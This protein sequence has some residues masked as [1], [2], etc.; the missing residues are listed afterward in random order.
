[1]TVGAAG[2]SVTRTR[3]SAAAM[4]TALGLMVLLVVGIGDWRIVRTEPAKAVVFSPPGGAYERD[5][6]LSLSAPTLHGE[7]VTTLDGSIPTVERGTR[8]VGP[9]RLSADGRAVTTIRARVVGRDGS[10]GPVRTESYFLGLDAQL[11]MM[12]LVIDPDDMWGA[13]R[14]IYANAEQ[15]GVEWERPVDIAYVDVDRNRGFHVPAGVRL[16]GEWSRQFDKK[17]LRLYF[18]DE[19]G[20]TQLAY[21]LFHTG[22]AATFDRLVLHNGGNDSTQPGAN[23]TLLRNALVTELA[24]AIGADTTRTRPVLL[25]VNGDPW[26]IYQLRERI[27]ERFLADRYGILQADILDSPANVWVGVTVEGDHEHWDELLAYVK[28][29]DLHEPESYT[30]VAAQVDLANLI[31]YTL[32]QLYSGNVDWPEHNVNQ[33]RARSPGGRWRWI[34]WDN[35][36]SFGLNLHA[37]LGFEGDIVTLD[38]VQKLFEDDHRRV[39]DGEDTLLTRKLLANEHFRGRFLA[40]AD[41]LLETAFSAEAVLPRIDRLAAEL[42][43]DIDHEIARWGSSVDWESSVEGMRDYARR[44][45]DALREHLLSAL[46]P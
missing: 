40:R 9:I 34:V 20:P 27:D 32:L 11:P 29:H 10:L 28:A 43:P 7:V 15:R 3:T 31:D 25:F 18:R 21:P 22:E 41:E 33:F 5:L 26:G 16:H 17:S 13:E 35:D 19:Y 36:Y 6:L 2:K 46:G 1:M 24:Q 39:V 30:Y 38:L 4:V 12:S 14:G 42:A 37:G 8:Y 44:R 23:W 45:P